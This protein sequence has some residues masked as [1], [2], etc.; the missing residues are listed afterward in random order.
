MVRISRKDEHIGAKKYIE[1]LVLSRNIANGKKIYEFQK[2]CLDG[3][4]ICMRG[5]YIQDPET[6]K[7]MGS[8]PSEK[9]DKSGDSAIIYMAMSQQTVD[10]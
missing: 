8:R 3:I 2:R 6:S 9:F 5:D 1:L 4:Y 10:K 7:M